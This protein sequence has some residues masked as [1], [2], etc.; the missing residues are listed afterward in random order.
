MQ[1]VEEN[2]RSLELRNGRIPRIFRN[3]LAYED[4]TN[5]QFA[6]ILCNFGL[7]HSF[8]H[9]QTAGGVNPTSGEL[10]Q[11][12]DGLNV[13]ELYA[14]IEFE[15]RITDHLLLPSGDKGSG[16]QFFEEYFPETYRNTITNLMRGTYQSWMRDCYS[17]S[18]GS[19]AFPYLHENFLR[20]VKMELLDSIAH[21]LGVLTDEEDT[22][23]IARLVHCFQ[24]GDVIIIFNYDLLIDKHLV[25]ERSADWSYLT[26][27]A[28]RPTSEGCRLHFVGTA[29][30]QPSKFKV[31]KLHG[32]SNWHFRFEHGSSV[33]MG[34]FPG[35][36]Q[37]PEPFGVGNLVRDFR[38]AFFLAT[39]NY[40]K[41]VV[42]PGEPEGF[43]ERFMIPPS[44]YKAE[45][46]FSA[47]FLHAPDGTALPLESSTLWLPQLLYRQA[48]HALK[49]ADRLVFIGF[50]MAP[51]DTSMRML[52]RAAADSNPLLR[53]VEIV[54]P[55][56]KVE[57]RIRSAIP[58]AQDYKR[59]KFF[60][61]VLNHWG[62]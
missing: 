56:D 35:Y 58:D 34:G 46:N 11:G 50:S 47:R 7:E 24:E 2:R 1:R 27:Y 9:L 15:S 33:G 30:G 38:L 48:L 51:A 49:A 53:L 43:F 21:T 5:S 60:D 22:S 26:G 23:N 55:E 12:W 44:T 59:Y 61:D 45:Y 8:V 13:E 52:F 10:V 25:Y 32:S 42:A 19:D 29:P 3:N 6:C 62:V 39:D 36:R 54:D 28:I 17:A 40:F 18:Y 31:L 14:A 4:D 20:V 16:S 37:V 41:R 57:E